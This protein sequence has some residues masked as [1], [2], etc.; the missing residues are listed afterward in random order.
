MNK[1]FLKEYFTFSTSVRRGIYVLLVLITLIIFLPYIYHIF[2]FTNRQQFSN[3]EFKSFDSAFSLI[4]AK[5]SIVYQ[6]PESKIDP[7]L[8]TENQWIKFGLSSKTVG[9]ITKYQKKGG[10][11]YS[12]NDLLKIYGFD[13]SVYHR[14]ENYLVFHK[15]SN[16]KVDK[17]IKIPF[18]VKNEISIQEIN[19][20]DTSELIKL[21]GI[22]ITLASRIIKYRKLLGGFVNTH[23]LLE[24]YGLTNDNFIKFSK[25]V[26]VDSNLVKK[27][28][29]NTI[30]QV[31]LMK[32]PY[33][34]KYKASVI[35]KYRK[36]KGKIESLN[37]L[38]KNG[39][40]KQD[41]ID[42]LSYYFNF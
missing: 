21:P 27:I 17:Q 19:S 24:V 32:H 26:S 42:K 30:S 1:K 33:I 41:E 22:G 13:T 40:L 20:A 15:V 31:E 18:I 25:Y 34:G 28:N 12:A 37:E 23:Q 39:I 3:N 16:I 36:F 5:E 14:I 4:K 7:N 38:A 35:I 6:I 29:L 2:I 9:I 10:R 8:L 11:F